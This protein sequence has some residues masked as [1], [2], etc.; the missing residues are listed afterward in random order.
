MVTGITDGTTDR[1]MV[2]IDGNNLYHGLRV[3]GWRTWVNVGE[4][5]KRAAGRRE[6]VATYY[7]NA[8]PRLIHQRLGRF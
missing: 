3:C 2:F 5:A 1:V 7:Y 6:L 8:R 4:F